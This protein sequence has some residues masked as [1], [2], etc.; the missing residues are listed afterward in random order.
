MRMQSRRH[1]VQDFSFTSTASYQP[2]DTSGTAAGEKSFSDLSTLA[3]HH[4]ARNMSSSSANISFGRGIR[5]RPTPVPRAES[6]LT[7]DS[8]AVEVDPDTGSEWVSLRY[9]ESSFA[10][11]NDGDIFTDVHIMSQQE[12]SSTSEGH[13]SSKSSSFE[14]KSVDLVVQSSSSDESVG[15][16]V[17]RIQEKTARRMA[18]EQP[19]SR[20]SEYLSPASGSLCALL[21]AM[22]M[23]NLLHFAG[24]PESAYS[25]P[26]EH[27]FTTG[28]VETSTSSL[29]WE[30]SV[31]Q[32]SK[33]P[34]LSP[35]IGLDDSEYS[36]PE[37]KSGGSIARNAQWNEDD[38]TYSLGSDDIDNVVQTITI[39]TTSSRA[40]QTMRHA[41]VQSHD[42]DKQHLLLL[43]EELSKAET[44]ISAEME[45]FSGDQWTQESPVR[46]RSASDEGEGEDEAEGDMSLDE[47]LG[48]IRG[49][50]AS[51]SSPMSGSG[52]SANTPERT[53]AK[54][55][56]PLYLPAALQRHTGAKE[57]TH[58]AMDAGES[59]QDVDSSYTSSYSLA[60]LMKSP[61]SAS[62]SS[63]RQE[64]RSSPTTAVP[65]PS[66]LS[67]PSQGTLPQNSDRQAMS[68]PSTPTSESIRFDR[69]DSTGAAATASHQGHL[70]YEQ[71]FE[72]S[73]DSTVDSAS[74]AAD[75]GAEKTSALNSSIGGKGNNQ[76]I[77]SGSSSDISL[78]VM[79][80]SIIRKAQTVDTFEMRSDP[81]EGGGSAIS[82]APRGSRRTPPQSPFK[83]IRA[84]SVLSASVEPSPEPARPSPNDHWRTPSSDTSSSHDS[85]VLILGAQVTTESSTRPSAGAVSLATT[86][87]SRHSD[88]SF[89]VKYGLQNLSSLVED[90]EDEH[91]E[92]SSFALHVDQ[93]HRSS[94]PTQSSLQTRAG[95][96]ES[97]EFDFSSS[98]S[99]SSR[100]STSTL[101]PTI[102]EMSTSRIPSPAASSVVQSSHQE[103]QPASD[104]R[105]HSSDYLHMSFTSDLSVDSSFAH[106][107]TGGSEEGAGGLSGSHL[108]GHAGE[109]PSDSV[110]SVSANARRHI[111]ADINS[112]R[113]YLVQRGLVSRSRH[114]S[115]DTRSSSASSTPSLLVSGGRVTGA[116]TV[117]RE[118]NTKQRS[119]ATPGDAYMLDL[120]SSESSVGE[121]SKRDISDEDSSGFDVVVHTSSRHTVLHSSTNITTS[122]REERDVY[123]SASSTPANT[124]SA[125]GQG[126]DQSPTLMSLTLRTDGTV[127]H[128]P[129]HGAN[130]SSLEFLLGIDEDESL[131]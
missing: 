73:M 1:F 94:L 27:D 128:A 77:S 54:G 103:P 114:P 86:S 30:I 24:R 105:R 35:A 34:Q 56:S 123:Y 121:S 130:D 84:T 82:A 98:P 10:L 118:L 78:S 111:Q 125:V 95:L 39:A 99:L 89:E 21:L 4:D 26:R 119:T 67:E 13:G 33:S 55:A 3:A 25:N 76:S 14:G 108:Y 90:D 58:Y 41:G 106:V 126:G 9:D 47:L 46:K 75:R 49:A 70:A 96:T 22:M 6:A 20:D 31:H 8:S 122:H 32:R 93:R 116:E 74:T 92:M 57:T 63:S 69:T 18:G 11:G 19:I 124:R 102:P 61:S 42:D 48:N 37:V 87:S 88:V 72:F 113:E 40:A 60:D 127:E 109:G 28:S 17:R 44:L 112:A 12:T 16:L 91:D 43:Q 107:G 68:T 104:W 23:I 36:L 45:M 81:S 71:M 65:H 59:R 100:S 64:K 101:V 115:G 131:G 83:A 7:S 29:Q 50:I 85:S 52:N 5:F 110:V 120:F 53:R 15:Q 62:P 80:S 129:L 79:T 2:A 38:S 97:P 51:S 117:V 66:R